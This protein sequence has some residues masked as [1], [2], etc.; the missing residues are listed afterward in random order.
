MATAK[1]MSAPKAVMSVPV[2]CPIAASVSLRKASFFG[3]TLKVQKT[4]TG[5]MIGARQAV[6]VEARAATKGGQQIQVGHAAFAFAHTHESIDTKTSSIGII[7]NNETAQKASTG[8]FRSVAD[9]L[10]VGA[11]GRGQAPGPSARAREERPPR[12]VCQRQ[13]CQSRHPGRRH[14]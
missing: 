3:P 6:K 11:G 4:S 13:C 10:A 12:Q 9:L 1:V 7:E 14:W 8:S 2:R 5:A